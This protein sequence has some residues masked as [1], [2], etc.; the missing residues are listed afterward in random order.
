MFGNGFQNPV[1]H[2][3]VFNQQMLRKPGW[4]ADFHLPWPDSFPH[5]E[6]QCAV[7]SSTKACAAYDFLRKRNIV[8]ASYPDL[9]L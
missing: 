9:S 2:R 4:P 5:A 3:M 1:H 8:T 6:K 7:V